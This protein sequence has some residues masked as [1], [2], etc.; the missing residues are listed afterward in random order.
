[1]FY[2]KNWYATDHFISYHFKLLIILTFH[3]K[4]L[5]KSIE[6]GCLSSTT[7]CTNASHCY[8]CQ[9]DGCNNLMGNNTQ[10]PLAPN[11]ATAW[12]ST[13]ALLLIPATIS[14]LLNF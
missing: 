11:S 7:Q 12:T 3:S 4:Y 1:M 10:V 14:L 9:G 13:M 5:A 2:P 8:T 6:R